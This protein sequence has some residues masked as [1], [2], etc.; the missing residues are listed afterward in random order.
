ATEDEP[1]M[2][3]ALV[4]Y[5]YNNSSITDEVE[6]PRGEHLRNYWQAIRRHILMVM[7]IALLS[8]LAVAV[9]EVRQPDQYEAVARIEVGHEESI[10]ELTDNKGGVTVSRSDDSVYFNTQLQILTSSALL[11][12]VV[13]T[14]ELDHN[15]NFLHPSRA[16]N[17]STWRGLLQLVGLSGAPKQPAPKSAVQPTAHVAAPISSDN[18]EEARRLKPYG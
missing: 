7:G 12:R 3:Q 14:L 5:T 17:Q 1:I 8:T 15:E 9:F 10:P 16:G 11:R 18:L 13:K 4:P 2:V 6:D